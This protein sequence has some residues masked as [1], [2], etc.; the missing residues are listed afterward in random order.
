[1]VSSA[2]AYAVICLFNSTPGTYVYA[3]PILLASMVY[4]N[5]RMVVLGCVVVIVSNIA[6]ILL[7]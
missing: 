4:L 3:I 2:I 6:R 7:S 5:L 1:M